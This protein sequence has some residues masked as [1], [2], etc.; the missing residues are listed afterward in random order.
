[1]GTGGGHIA[2]SCL[3]DVDIKGRNTRKTNSRSWTENFLE[4]SAISIVDGGWSKRSHITSTT[5]IPNLESLARRLGNFWVQNKYNHTCYRNWITSSSEMISWK[6]LMLIVTF[7]CRTYQAGVH[8]TIECS[9]HACKCYRGALEHNSWNGSKGSWKSEYSK[10][11][12]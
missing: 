6:V 10:L 7:S 1:M 12:H 9:N 11:S 5:W 3:S 8:C 4:G 2:A